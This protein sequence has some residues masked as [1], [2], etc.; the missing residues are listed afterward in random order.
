ME[1][2]KTTKEDYRFEVSNL[3]N[4]RVIY[5]NHRGVL[6]YVEEDKRVIWKCKKLARRGYVVIN[7]SRR[8]FFVHRLVASNFLENPHNKPQVNH[9]DAVKNNNKLSNLEWCTNRENV[10]HAFELGLCPKGENSKAS[11]LKEQDILCIKDLLKEKNTKYSIAKLY[12]VSRNTIH[13]IKE[14]ITWKHVR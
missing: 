8:R 11:K 1:I 13:D 14:G 5:K 4:I 3:G 10:D 9:I 7:M 2:W 12:G 6:T